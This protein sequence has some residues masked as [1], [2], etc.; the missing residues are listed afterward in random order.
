MSQKQVILHKELEKKFAA[1]EYKTAL[2]LTIEYYY[3]MFKKNISKNLLRKYAKGKPL[4]YF[5]F[6]SPQEHSTL[7][8]IKK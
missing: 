2:N 6:F 4:I 7:I 3:L 1:A 5:S 8:K